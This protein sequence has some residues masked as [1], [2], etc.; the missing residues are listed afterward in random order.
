M[1]KTEEERKREREGLLEELAGMGIFRRGSVNEFFRRCGTPS[2]HCHRQGDP[3]H[4]PQTT[5][6]WKEGDKTRG[7]NLATRAEAE[8]AREQVENHDRFREWLR[9]WQAWNEEQADWELSQART[10]PRPEETALK[11]KLSRRSGKR[12]RGKSSV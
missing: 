1:T 7:R 11:K 12:R 6:T 9:K 3:G 5:L 4:G 8:R 10:E 2:C